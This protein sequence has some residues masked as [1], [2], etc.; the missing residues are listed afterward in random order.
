VNRD[1]ILIEPTPSEEVLPDMKD[2]PFYQ[3]AL[4]I[5]DD[6]GYLITG[7]LK[8]FPKKPFVVKARIF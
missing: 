8:H 2:L 6:N 1:G 5:K 7:N 4:D 3:V